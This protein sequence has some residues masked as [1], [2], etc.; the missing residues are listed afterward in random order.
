MST[1]TVARDT[2]LATPELL[3][4]ILA[5]LPLHALLLRV[6]LVCRLWHAT[7]RAPALQCALFFLPDPDPPSS[8]SASSEFSSSSAPAPAPAPVPNPLLA[9]LFPPFFASPPPPDRYTWP[10]AH[11][12]MAMP[13]ARTP[14][15]FAR[16][17][18]SW[19]G[20]LVARPPVRALRVVQRVHARGGDFARSATVEFRGAGRGEGEGEGEGGELRM[21]ALYDLAAGGVKRAGS[22]FCVTWH[23]GE[24]EGRE[25]DVT[26]ET[27]D[28]M[29][30]VDGRAGPLTEAFYGHGEGPRV[31]FAEW[32][33]VLREP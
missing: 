28:T 6:P 30:F 24:G 23:A 14:A 29:Q 7:T 13:A 1:A 11:A 16:A 12:L 4:H 2:V 9:A 17:D 31:K 3:E 5:Q 33:C 27:V 22:A 26:L 21:G 8:S 10:T 18:A 32:V 15:A 25:C 19:R 20:M